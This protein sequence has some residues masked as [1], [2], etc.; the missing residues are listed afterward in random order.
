MMPKIMHTRNR[1]KM[2]KCVF[3]F[4]GNTCIIINTIS[5]EK[6]KHVMTLVNSGM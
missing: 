1:G 3:I 6:K 2:C 4:F 5:A